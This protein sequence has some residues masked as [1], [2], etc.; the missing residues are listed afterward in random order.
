MFVIVKQWVCDN[1][2]LEEIL[3]DFENH[4]KNAEYQNA[5]DALAHICECD[6]NSWDASVIHY[7]KEIKD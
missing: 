2:I 7:V 3:Q 6:M 5:E 4:E 1:T